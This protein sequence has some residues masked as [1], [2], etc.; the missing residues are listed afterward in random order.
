[1][2][3]GNLIDVWRLNN[4]HEQCYNLYQGIT[5]K[6]ARLDYFLISPNL[7]DIIIGT[8][9]DPYDNLSVRAS[10]SIEVG[11]NKCKKGRW[12]WRFDNTMLKDQEFLDNMNKIIRDTRS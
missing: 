7:Y 8:G 11:K 12:F 3:T 4:P 9:I 2:V 10:T 1:M 5:E 6:R